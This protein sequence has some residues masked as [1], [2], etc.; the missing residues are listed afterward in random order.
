MYLSLLGSEQL[1]KQELLLSLSSL[2]VLRTE[3]CTQLGGPMQIVYC[4]CVSVSSSARWGNRACQRI[5]ALKVC[6]C[7][8]QHVCMY[9]FYPEVIILREG[10]MV[11][12]HLFIMVTVLQM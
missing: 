4:L 1:W 10:T 5:A 11:F 2:V 8:C 3:A 9:I 7:V 6:L 12:I